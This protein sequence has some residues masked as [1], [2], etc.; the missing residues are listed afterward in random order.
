[1]VVMGAQWVNIRILSYG[2]PHEPVERL[3]NTTL[4]RG[5]LCGY[6]YRVYTTKVNIVAC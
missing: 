1:M 3:T 2:M 6:K 4:Q 5:Y